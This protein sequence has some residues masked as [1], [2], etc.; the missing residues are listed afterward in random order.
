MNNIEIKKKPFLT[1]LI[2]YLRYSLWDLQYG[3]KFL[4]GK[5]FVGNVARGWHGSQNSDY[6]ALEAIF[7]AV[8]I[9]KSDV[10][11]DVGCGKG[12]L[13]NFLLAKKLSNRMIGVE[14]DQTTFEFT[15]NRLRHFLQVEIIRADVEC[16]PVPLEGTIFYLFNPFNQVIVQKFADCLIERIKDNV[17]QDK[18]RPLIIYY[19]ISNRLSVFTENPL[20]K[21]QHLVNISHTGLDA[22]LIE[23][24]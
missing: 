1:R 24:V 20:W 15:K 7:S 6:H 23:P 18:D 10:I 14:V 4:M 3:R 16:D 2:R 19:N 5:C 13:F 21:V 17:Y 12:R 22:V 9:K 8:E 11:V